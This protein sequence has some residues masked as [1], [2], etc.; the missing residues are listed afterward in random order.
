METLVQQYVA[1]SSN[2]YES[3]EE[4]MSNV[5][6]LWVTEQM[7]HFYHNNVIAA[8]HNFKLHSKLSI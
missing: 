2:H 4:I 8:D 3:S 5:Y 7:A 6:L 1:N